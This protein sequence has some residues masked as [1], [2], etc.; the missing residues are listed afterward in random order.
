MA[1][2][3]RP[4]MR[5]PFSSVAL[6]G[7]LAMASTLL[8]PTGRDPADTNYNGF[9]VFE[10][11]LLV[12]KSFRAPRRP[13]LV[14]SRCSHGSRG[15]RARMC[16]RGPEAAMHQLE[17]FRHPAMTCRGDTAMGSPRSR[18]PAVARPAGVVHS[19]HLIGGW[20][21]PAFS[22]GQHRGGETAG[23]RAGVSRGRRGRLGRHRRGPQSKGS[24]SPVPSTAPTDTNRRSGKEQGRQPTLRS[25][26]TGIERDDLPGVQRLGPGRMPHD[27]GAAPTWSRASPGN[28]RSDGMPAGVIQ[29]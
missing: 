14:G 28:E 9:T 27:D 29:T 12:T 2:S 26:R 5:H 6:A 22:V 23:C 10:A 25:P 21:L 4:Q 15:P 11:G 13:R 3:R 16:K 1:R 8:R 18:E 24:R 17:P 20:S 19:D 7:G